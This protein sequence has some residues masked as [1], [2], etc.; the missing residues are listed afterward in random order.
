MRKIKNGRKGFTLLEL[1]IVVLIIGILAAI[2]L[3]QYR[4]AVA[5]TQ[6]AQLLNVTKSFVTSLHSYYLT[7]DKFPVKTNGVNGINFLDIS[8]SN[9]DT[10]CSVVDNGTNTTVTFIYCNNK[11]FA[12]WTAVYP[13]KA[14][15]TEIGMNSVEENPALSYAAKELFGNR[16]T[17]C[18]HQ[19]T[20][21]TCK[22]LGLSDSGCF[23]CIGYKYL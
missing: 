12:V 23:T 16:L 15:V 20:S 3:P 21:A 19:D 9:E 17:K 7:N 1:L 10:K 22:R 13:N 11:N 6:L 14:M 2:A 4:K 8:I 18:Y 5:K